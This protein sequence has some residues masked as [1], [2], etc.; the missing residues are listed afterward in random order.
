MELAAFIFGFAAAAFSAC[1]ILYSWRGKIIRMQ[2]EIDRAAEESDIVLD[3]M[4]KIVGDVA[5]GADMETLQ[6]RI[7]RAVT[8]GCGATSAAIYEPVEG[9]RFRATAIEGAFPPQRQI[10]P[11]VLMALDSRTDLI[12]KILQGEE[13]EPR[14]GIVGEVA[15]SREPVI[16]RKA[17]GSPRVV[18]HKDPSLRISSIMAVPLTFR[19]EFY[20]VIAIANPIG[21]GSFSDMDFSVA[22]SIADQA[23]LSI[24]NINS[25]NALVEKSKLDYDLT[26][27]SSV[28][29]YLLPSK[30]PELEGFD[31]AVKYIPQQKIGGDFYDAFI[32]PGGKL[33]LV[34]GDVSGKGIAA[35][36]IM[37]QCQTSLRYIAR[38]HD[39]PSEALKAL[40]RAMVSAMRSDMFITIIYAVI[41][42]ADGS[43]RIA[44]AGHEK[45]LVYDAAKR[46]AYFLKSKG[47]A[48]GMVEPEIF[49]AAITDIEDVFEVGEFLVLY[50]DGIT[51]AAAPDG[52]EFS[53]GRLREIVQNSAGLSASQLCARITDSVF[54]F[55]CRDKLIDDDFTLFTIKRTK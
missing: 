27:A 17:V 16:I 6:A 30:L 3:F 18:N 31:F 7:L 42:P 48:V 53:T 43:I 24:F 19:D 26:L 21:G 45:P 54:A 22:R 39:R 40:N 46:E 36:I 51:E 23:S 35:A 10:S 44:R 2:E 50:T 32:L 52:D 13:L 12:E 5:S 29:C 28:Q 47:I 34:V 1:W 4:H 25:F 8:L 14:E 49:D 38:E 37:S 33:G 11:S 20:G 9:G 41:D 15:A 55:T